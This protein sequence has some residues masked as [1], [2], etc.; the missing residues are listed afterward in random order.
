MTDRPFVRVIEIENHD[1]E[2][3]SCQLT[4]CLLCAIVFLRYFIGTSETII[5][6]C[7]LMVICV[8]I[9]IILVSIVVSLRFLVGKW[10][11]RKRETEILK[12]KNEGTKKL[13]TD[14]YFPLLR[15]NTKRVEDLKQYTGTRYKRSNRMAE[16]KKIRN[17]LPQVE[18]FDTR[19]HRFKQNEELKHLLCT[20][21][22]QAAVLRKA[23]D[24]IHEEENS[25]HSLKRRLLL[26]HVKEKQERVSYDGLPPPLKTYDRQAS[27]GYEEKV[28]NCQMKHKNRRKYR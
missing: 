5:I 19:C 17:F 9:S 22:K 11:E 12:L 28:K 14:R 23:I 20:L 16:L 24:Q 1:D 3:T 13:L 8:V 18:I 4:I 7:T 25:I 15:Q 26:C 27:D 10:E 6:F 2:L 21:N